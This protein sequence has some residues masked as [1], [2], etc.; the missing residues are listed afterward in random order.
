[1]NTA[2][3]RQVEFLMLSDALKQ[4]RGFDFEGHG[5]PAVV[6]DRA[7]PP[8]IR[9]WGWWSPEEPG[10]AC[11]LW[12]GDRGWCAAVVEPDEPHSPGYELAFWS[13]RIKLLDLAL[14]NALGPY[15]TLG[16]LELHVAADARLELGPHGSTIREAM[17][18]GIVQLRAARSQRRPTEENRPDKPATGTQSGVVDEEL[19]QHGLAPTFPKRRAF[20]GH[21]KHK[22]PA[23]DAL[24]RALRSVRLGDAATEDE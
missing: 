7:T 23:V 9:V 8:S 1:M 12:R 4:C 10:T 17:L 18:W 15:A 11:L 6:L 5:H 13:H 16:Q 14:A 24:V 21:R 20:S 22:D 2:T 3:A 19:V